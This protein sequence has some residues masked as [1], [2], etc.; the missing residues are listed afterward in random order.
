LLDVI[1][2]WVKGGISR[3]DAGLQKSRAVLLF[4]REASRELVVL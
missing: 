1:D 3:V 2:G 4:S